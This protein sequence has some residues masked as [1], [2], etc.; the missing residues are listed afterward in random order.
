MREN[1]LASRERHAMSIVALQLK[2]EDK[3]KFRHLI[4]CTNARPIEITKS[5][6]CENVLYVYLL[7]YTQYLYLHIEVNVQ[8]AGYWVS[9]IS[10]KFKTSISLMLN[11]I[12]T[13]NSIYALVS[14]L[15]MNTN[16][17]YT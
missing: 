4:L 5:I 7:E 6:K 2:K 14:S 11:I 16:R 9:V 13:F 12:P 17:I 8:I 3:K 15:L 10:C 1:T